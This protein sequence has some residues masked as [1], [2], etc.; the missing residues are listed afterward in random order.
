MSVI[1]LFLISVVAVASYGLLFKLAAFLLKRSHLKWADSFVFGLLVLIVLFG[2]RAIIAAV[3]PDSGPL[4]TSVISL[5]LCL[6]LGGWFFGIRARNSAGAQLG[7]SGGLLLTGIGFVLLIAV[8]L[9]ILY[10]A[11]VLRHP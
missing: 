7:W 10:A 6:G 8:G 9:A 3:L 4:T 5:S 11:Q 1:L 2:A